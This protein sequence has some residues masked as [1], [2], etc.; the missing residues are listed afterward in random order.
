VS[1]A[2]QGFRVWCRW[3]CWLARKQPKKQLRPMVK[4][5]RMIE[6][7][8]AGILAHWKKGG[9]NAFAEGLNSVFRTTKRK[10]RGYCSRTQLITM[11]ISS[12]AS[13]ASSDS[14]ASSKTV[15]NL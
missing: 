7:Y 9:T 10:A 4:V 1:E 13:S 5:A 6:P 12:P 14:E 15:G 8:L 3:V 11:A 2:R